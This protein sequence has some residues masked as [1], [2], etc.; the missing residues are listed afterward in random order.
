LHRQLVPLR[1]SSSPFEHFEPARV[2]PN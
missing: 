1:G 2:K